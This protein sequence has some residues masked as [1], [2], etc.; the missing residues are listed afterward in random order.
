MRMAYATYNVDFPMEFDK[1]AEQLAFALNAA[2][3]DCVL[4]AAREGAQLL[5]G[6]EHRTVSE[7]DTDSYRYSWPGCRLEGPL[8][9]LRAGSVFD[10]EHTKNAVMLAAWLI[11]RRNAFIGSLEPEM[12]TAYR[13]IDA[14]VDTVIAADNEGLF[15]W[16]IEIDD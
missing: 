8:V 2:R 14:L 13:A 10:P 3:E 15:P 5:I 11:K 9:E 16:E 4:K 12:V 1:V 6:P 7:R